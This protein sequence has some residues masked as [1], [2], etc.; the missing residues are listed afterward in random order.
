[1]NSDL[2][3]CRAYILYQRWKTV[4]KKDQW[5]KMD[6]VMYTLYKRSPNS[7][8]ESSILRAILEPKLNTVVMT[9]AESLN[10]GLAMVE[11]YFKV[12]H[13]K[14]NPMMED[15]LVFGSSHIVLSDYDDDDEDLVGF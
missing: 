13:G 12:V 6:D 2:E 11:E 1:M 4:V 10:P 7:I 9:V 8:R 15:E 3:F 5:Q 14:T